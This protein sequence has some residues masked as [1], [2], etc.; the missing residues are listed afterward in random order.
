MRENVYEYSREKLWLAYGLAI[1][2]SCAIVI[3]GLLI[4]LLHG[5]AFED[6]FSTCLRLSRGAIIDAEIREQDFSGS[7]PLPG[8]VK[9]MQIRFPKGSEASSVRRGTY[10]AVATE[11]EQQDKQVPTPS[12]A[13]VGSVSTLADH[14][15]VGHDALAGQH[16]RTTL[17]N[18]HTGST[19]DQ[20]VLVAS[21]DILR[22]NL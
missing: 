10:E 21:A 13:S 8:Y 14:G 4:I 9:K 3:L 16:E 5:A 18:D 2:T 20:V 11:S 22:P 17:V 12:H 7:A 15:A 19:E 1:G 6:E